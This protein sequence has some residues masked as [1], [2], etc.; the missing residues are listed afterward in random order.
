MKFEYVLKII[1]RTN[2][3]DR[4]QC[5]AAALNCRVTNIMVFIA[6]GELKLG[7]RINL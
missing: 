3:V 6:D 2:F 4:V 1:Y 7:R 5:S